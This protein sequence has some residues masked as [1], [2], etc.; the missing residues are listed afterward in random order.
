MNW[1]LVTIAFLLSST[2][3]FTLFPYI[4]NWIEKKKIRNEDNN[5]FKK[6]RVQS[7]EGLLSVLL[8]FIVISI[9]LTIQNFTDDININTYLLFTSFL[10]IAVIA[11]IGFVD[12]ILRFPTHLIRN[13]FFICAIMPILTAVINQNNPFIDGTLNKS[14]IY[15]F[16]AVPVVIIV[17]SKLFNGVKSFNKINLALGSIIT[18]ALFIMAVFEENYTSQLILSTIGGIII[19]LQM[20]NLTNTKLSLG[21]VGRF[22]LG[23]IVACAAILQNT[24]I[25]FLILLIPYLVYYFLY[26]K[27]FDREQKRLRSLNIGNDSP[28]QTDKFQNAFLYLTL[29][30]II[31]SIV[32]L[33]AYLKL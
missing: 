24:I 33:T 19:F 15:L 12:D 27:S 22:S 32:A 30:E 14:N 9:I 31:F 18:I 17:S 29:L 1:I 26:K 11:F 6:P 5:K 4:K 25:P 2:L 7:L 20:Y 23:A 10:S 21:K 3:S 8:F 16:I 28:E 13:I